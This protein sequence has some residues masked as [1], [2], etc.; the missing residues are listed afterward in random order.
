MFSSIQWLLQEELPGDS[1]E[2]VTNWML[3][4]PIN[5]EFVTNDLM[6]D[7]LPRVDYANATGK[8]LHEVREPFIATWGEYVEYCKVPGVWAADL[9]QACVQRCYARLGYTVRIWK[10][11]SDDN[12]R[13]FARDDKRWQDNPGVLS[14]YTLLR[15]INLRSEGPGE[16]GFLDILH[17]GGL[18]FRALKTDGADILSLDDIVRAHN[19]PAS[20]AQEEM[21]SLCRKRRRAV[22]VF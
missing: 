20:A 9:M 1:R 10:P 12:W 22:I 4:N 15:T 19:K 3:E 21:V 17:Y 8:P 11:C 13:L 2:L 16:H 5:P 7:L 14:R 6:R 18:H